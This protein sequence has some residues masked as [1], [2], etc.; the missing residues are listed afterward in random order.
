MPFSRP[1]LTQIINRI[2]S[3]FKTR[4]PGAN[5]LLR[6]S[7]LSVIARTNAGAFHSLYEYL[8]YQ[9]KQLFIS[10][11]DSAGLETHASEYGIARTAATQAVGS[12]TA[13]GT[14]GTI[15]PA[16]TELTLSNGNIYSID[17]EAV[18]ATGSA[19]VSF[20]SLNAGD[21]QNDD[22]G[23]L[24]TFSSPI[25]GINTTVTVDS[26][27]IYNGT[28]E[29]TDEALR[30]RLLAR[31]RQPPH[32]GASF[33]YLAWILEISGNTRAWISEEYQ[34][35][36]TI[37][38]IYVRDDDTSIIPND[39]QRATTRAYIVEHED[40]VTGETVG[41]PVTAEPGIYMVTPTLLTLDFE[42]ELSVNDSTTRTAVT[43]NIEDLI[44]RDGGEGNTIYLSNVSE[45]I[46]LSAGESRHRILS[47]VADITT[48]ITQ[49]P[50]LGTITF[51]DYS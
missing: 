35:V 41:C 27:G 44:L 50:E 49:I 17:T 4:I 31:K 23:V 36:G 10:T 40:P 28:D 42:I 26:D 24:L 21:D 3:D 8:D 2:V 1:A 46:S 25:V 47:P 19:T 9:A 11:A 34:G 48:T 13:T 6:R 16:D 18:I 20:T 15:I 51:S 12:G 30:A 22:A 43:S 29:E 33:D 37:G 45:A 39:T 7:V 32:G 38:L 14:N 5:S